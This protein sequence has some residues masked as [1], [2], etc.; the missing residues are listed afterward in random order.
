MAKVFFPGTVPPAQR[1]QGMN[2]F[3]PSGRVSDACC[4]RS[5]ARVGQSSA[6]REL[7][8]CP[9]RGERTGQGPRIRHQLSDDGDQAI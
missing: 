3:V 8:R 7:P 6:S 1:G 5:G 2:S 4:A 9:V